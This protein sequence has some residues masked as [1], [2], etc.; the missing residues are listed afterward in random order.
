MSILRINMSLHRLLDLAM[1]APVIQTPTPVRKDRRGS[2]LLYVPP[3]DPR[4]KTKRWGFQ[5]SPQNF[6]SANLPAME[7]KLRELDA[8]EL[9]GHV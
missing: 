6:K 7:K 2:F 4:S 3:V 5:L 8:E 9:V 1:L